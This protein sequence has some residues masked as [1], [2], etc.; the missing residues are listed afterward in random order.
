MPDTGFQFDKEPPLTTTSDS[1]KLFDDSDSV[2]VRVAVSPAPSDATSELIAMV[3]R[4]VSMES[5]T[6]L[7][8][9]APSALVLPMASENFELATEITPLLVLLA[10]GVNVA[11]YVVPDPEKLESEP[12]EMERSDSTKSDDDSERLKEMAAD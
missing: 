1:T 3:G 2:K 6:E 9:S 10:V 12:P 4:R 7:F 8:A 11:E 5:S